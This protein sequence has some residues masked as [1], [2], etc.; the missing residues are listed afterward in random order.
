MCEHTSFEKYPDD[1]TRV[2]C[3]ECN[4][5]VLC[6]HPENVIIGPGPHASSGDHVECTWCNVAWLCKHEHQD[7]PN[8]GQQYRFCFD[9]RANIPFTPR[10]VTRSPIGSARR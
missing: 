8:L 6:P 4:E 3:R 10:P 9:C 5:L 1:N 7:S 2:R